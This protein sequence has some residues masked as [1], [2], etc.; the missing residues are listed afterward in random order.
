VKKGIQV[1]HTHVIIT[2]EDQSVLA[3]RDV[4]KFGYLMIVSNAE[5]ENVK[6]HYGIDPLYPTFTKEN[7]SRAFEKRQKPLKAVLMDQSL[8]AG[9]GNIYADEICHRTKIRPD[10][11][12]SKLTQKQ[13]DELYYASSEIIRTAVDHKGTT[14]RDFAGADGEPGNYAFELKAYGRQGERCLQC[15]SGIIEKIIFHGRGT[16]YCRSCQL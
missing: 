6:K 5:L 14:F 12:S 2:F 13:L 9:I 3:F 10:K 16:H 15:S 8:I 7:F 4:R 11:P 1:Q